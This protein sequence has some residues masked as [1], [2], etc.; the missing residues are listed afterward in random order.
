MHE[1]G[2]TV[3]L[4]LVDSSVERSALD[5]FKSPEI[6][7]SVLKSFNLQI[8]KTA[9]TDEKQE[10]L[11]NLQREVARNLRLMTQYQMQYFPWQITFLR[12]CN[13]LDDE[14]RCGRDVA[15][16]YGDLVEDL[17]V[18]RIAGDHYDVFE[19]EHISFTSAVIRKIL[20][21]YK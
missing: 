12:A 20:R 4:I 1:R 14:K 7:A 15:N 21:R 3:L 8:E 13:D 6:A 2:H 10:F 19:D 16:G 5:K 18:E 9:R 11:E 17:V